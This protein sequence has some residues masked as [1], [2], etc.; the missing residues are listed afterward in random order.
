MNNPVIA[1]VD[2]NSYDVPVLG[3]L[4]GQRSVSLCV[5]Y[6]RVLCYRLSVTVCATC[7]DGFFYVDI[8]FQKYGGS[9]FLQASS[10]STVQAAETTPLRTYT[11]IVHNTHMVSFFMQPISDT[12]TV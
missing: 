2:I 1:A 4:L 7:R 6:H 3:A 5:F 11:D 8:V 10:T 9:L 12:A